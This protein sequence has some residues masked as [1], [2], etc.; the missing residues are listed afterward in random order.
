MID[1]NTVVH[2]TFGQQQHINLGNIA[3]FEYTAPQSNGRL[4]LIFSR[5]GTVFNRD[6]LSEI[7]KRVSKVIEITIE[8]GEGKHTYEVIL[9]E[10]KLKAVD[11]WEQLEITA[12]R[13]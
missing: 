10:V 1:Q 9:E 13:V 6:D 5:D 8:S 7:I 4:N 12:V 11:S 3:I 2:V